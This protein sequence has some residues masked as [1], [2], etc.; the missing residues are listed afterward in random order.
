MGTVDADQLADEFRRTC[1]GSVDAL[2]QGQKIRIVG[3]G[4]HAQMIATLRLL[5]LADL[6][7]DL[8]AVCLDVAPGIH[9]ILS[10]ERWVSAQQFRLRTAQLAGPFQESDGNPRP[11][12]TRF[13]APHARRAFDARNRPGQLAC[14]PLEQFRPFAR[15]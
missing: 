5:V 2:R 10:A 4:H 15:R 13:P 12:N 3:A 9:E 7:F 11:G 1:Q 14:H 8:L 6:L